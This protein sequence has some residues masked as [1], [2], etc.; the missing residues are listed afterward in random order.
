MWYVLEGTLYLLQPKKTIQ[1]H[2]LGHLLITHL[3]I[4]PRRKNNSST[5]CSSEVSTLE[6][7]ITNIG[8]LF[9]YRRQNS[10]SKIGFC[11]LNTLV[12][13]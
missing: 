1:R 11:D 3:H 5:H 7:K 2:P 10:D 9:H 12:L 8:A 6:W 4:L 13:L